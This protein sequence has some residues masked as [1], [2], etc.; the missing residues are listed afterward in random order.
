MTHTKVEAIY[1]IRHKAS[2]EFVRAN[3]KGCWMSVAAAKSSWRNSWG[4]SLLA[5][6]TFGEESEYEIVNLL[7]YA[8]SSFEVFHEIIDGVHAKCYELERQVGKLQGDLED[9]FLAHPNLRESL[10][11]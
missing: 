3:G 8:S 11:Y 1:A 2:G 9:C 6:Q 5:C 10:G 7:G 4:Y